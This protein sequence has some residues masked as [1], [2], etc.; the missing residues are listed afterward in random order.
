M[1]QQILLNN[2]EVPGLAGI[3]V[4]RKLGG[5]SSVEKA[6]NSMTPDEVTGEVAIGTEGPWRGRIS[7]RNEVE[8]SG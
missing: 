4:Y 7:N 5:Y 8:F 6:L 3:E 2:I 1:V